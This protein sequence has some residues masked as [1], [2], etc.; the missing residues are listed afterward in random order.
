MSCIFRGRFILFSSEIRMS[1]A[2][3]VISVKESD[4]FLESF[5]AAKAKKA[6]QEL[7]RWTFSKEA[8][9]LAS[10]EIEREIEKKGREVQRLMLQAHFEARGAGEKGPFL[11][12]MRGE[13]NTEGEPQGGA[14]LLSHRRMHGRRLVSIF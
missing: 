9:G 12:V 8:I 11:E 1:T 6:F 5:S 10:H 2:I 3:Q 13:G 4:F 14:T 7:E